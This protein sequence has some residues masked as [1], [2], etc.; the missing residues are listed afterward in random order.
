MNAPV[1]VE[2]GKS[3]LWAFFVF[4]ALFSA[5]AWGPSVGLHRSAIGLLTALSGFVPVSVELMTGYTIDRMWVTR[6]SR[7]A[8]PARYWTS[9]ASTV[10][11]ALV[12]AVVGVSLA[13]GGL[14]RFFV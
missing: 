8:H 7:V 12:V 2:E 4:A 3:F 5:S 9:I 10:M 1:R 14:S 11:F 13:V 6:I